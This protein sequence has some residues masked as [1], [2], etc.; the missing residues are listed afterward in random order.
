M[1]RFWKMLKNDILDAKIDE[2]FAQFWRNF[3]NILL[4]SRELSPG[5]DS[6]EAWSSSSCPGW[7]PGCW[8]STG[9]TAGFQ[10]R[11]IFVRYAGPSD[12]ARTHHSPS[13]ARSR[14]DRRRF[15]RPNTH[16]QH[17]STSTRK[18]SSREQ[19]LQSFGKFYKKLCKILQNFTPVP[20]SWKNYEHLQN[21]L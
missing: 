20:E 8:G 10:M 21:L 12:W 5:T 11:E 13:E 19:I 4:K 17:F 3:D 16:F 9:T 2:D 18:S 15:W 1:C 6:W 7:R 14:L